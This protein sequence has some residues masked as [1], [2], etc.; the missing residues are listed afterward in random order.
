MIPWQMT[1]DIVLGVNRLEARKLYDQGSADAAIKSL[2]HDEKVIREYRKEKIRPRDKRN[3]AS[4][5]DLKSEFL[6]RQSRGSE[7]RT[8]AGEI[9]TLLSGKNSYS[10]AEQ[11]MQ[12]AA[13]NTLDRVEESKALQRKLESLGVAIGG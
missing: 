9:L 5:N 2:A 4:L 12:L 3:I 1:T 6:T 11:K 8:A 10:I 7:A 13:Y